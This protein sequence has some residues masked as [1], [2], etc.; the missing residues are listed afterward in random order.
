MV[1]CLARKYVNRSRC[2]TGNEPRNSFATG[3]SLT[4]VPHRMRGGQSPKAGRNLSRIYR[5]AGFTNRRSENTKY[6]NAKHKAMQR[7]EGFS[8]WMNLRCQASVIF[9]RLGRTVPEQARRNSR[10]RGHSLTLLSNENGSQI[11]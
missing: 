10:D 6:L 2:K 7:R 11:I 8:F 4:V 9:V 1:S 5:L 3:K